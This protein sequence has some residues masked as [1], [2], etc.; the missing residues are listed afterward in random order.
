MVEHLLN[1]MVQQTLGDGQGLPLPSFLLPANSLHQLCHGV[2][3]GA[4]PR[5]LVPLS[6]VIMLGREVS[7]QCGTWGGKI[8]SPKKHLKLGNCSPV[9][10]RYSF[11]F[12][13]ISTL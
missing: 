2:M 13:F 5:V 12:V 3:Q 11:A 4:G 10:N 7:P 6:L 9:H 1:W 8:L